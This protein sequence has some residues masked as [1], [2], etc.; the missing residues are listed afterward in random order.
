M[1]R[2][3][4][5]QSA[6]RRHARRWGTLPL[7]P[8]ARWFVCGESAALGAAK[9]SSLWAA[10]A[11]WARP[12]TRS[13]RRPRSVH[14]IRVTLD[15]RAVRWSGLPMPHRRT[16]ADAIVASAHS[17]RPA[18]R[19]PAF[20]WPLKPAP[21]PWATPPD[22]MVQQDRLGREDQVGTVSQCQRPAGGRAARRGETSIASS[23][24]S[25]P[26]K[27]CA[28]FR[29]PVEAALPAARWARPSTRSGRRPRSVN[30]T[31]PTPGW[32]PGGSARRTSRFAPPS[33]SL[34][35]PWMARQALYSD[36]HPREPAVDVQ[37][38]AG[39][40]TARHRGAEQ[41]RGAHQLLRGAEAGHRRLA[42]DRRRPL[43]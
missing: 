11:R 22:P 4:R 21:G 34:S 14:L 3:S 9:V 1:A 30:L 42:H 25:W 43:R 18:L 23:P 38:G 31:V 5:R 15:S 24:P 12:S 8:R 7:R 16:F 6:G 10:A 37:L 41:D 26:A 19:H 2:Q 39:D 17:D 13:G 28:V 27:P 35:G 20:A 33:A 36:A 29:P 32:R 40:E